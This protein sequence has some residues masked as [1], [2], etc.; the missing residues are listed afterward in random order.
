MTDEKPLF[1]L[2]FIVSAHSLALAEFIAHPTEVT[3][4]EIFA[5]TSLAYAYA[6]RI[7]EG[8]SPTFSAIELIHECLRRHRKNQI[9][10]CERPRPSWLDDRD[11]WD[12]SGPIEELVDGEFR[13]ENPYWRGLP[14]DKSVELN[15][16]AALRDR[17]E[18]RC[19]ELANAVGL[20]ETHVRKKLSG[21]ADQGSVE[22]KKRPTRWSLSERLTNEL[23]K[24]SKP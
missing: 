9:A 1:K 13:P 20:S 16:L 14:G 7:P 24:I 6:D 18:Q 2:T 11:D 4:E 22:A 17:P 10:G 19:H 12:F 23:S 15:I 8:H 5:V 21:L 3:L